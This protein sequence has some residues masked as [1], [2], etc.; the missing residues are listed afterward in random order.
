MTMTKDLVVHLLF[1]LVG[2]VGGALALLYLNSLQRDTLSISAD[3]VQSTDPRAVHKA[4]TL[5]REGRTF[6]AAR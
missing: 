4:P 1:L 2:A 3:K 5:V 6:P